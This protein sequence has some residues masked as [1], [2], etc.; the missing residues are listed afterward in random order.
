MVG[1]TTAETIGAKLDA[2]GTRFN[3]A[4]TDL[5]DQFRRERAMLWALGAVQWH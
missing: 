5:R 4:I 3:D 2:Q 1:C